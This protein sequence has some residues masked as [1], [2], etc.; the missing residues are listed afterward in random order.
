MIFPLKNI[1][2]NSY[3]YFKEI[4]SEISKCL[5]NYESSQV[6]RTI[7]SS[8]YNLSDLQINNFIDKYETI[9]KLICDQIN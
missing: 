5:K 1:F 8:D 2:D 6:Y 9:I 4:I 3:Q 7:I